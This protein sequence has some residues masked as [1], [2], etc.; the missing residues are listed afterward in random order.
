MIETD[1][2]TFAAPPKVG[3]VW[4]TKTL[5]RCGIPFVNGGEHTWGTTP[6][7]PSVTTRRDPANW[8]VSWWSHFH[9]YGPKQYRTYQPELKPLRECI[10]ED[11]S[12]EEFVERY[13]NQMPGQITRGYMAYPADFQMQTETLAVN[14]AD[15]LKMLE[16]P[17]ENAMTYEQVSYLGPENYTYKR[18]RLNPILTA[19]VRMCEKK[20]A[21]ELLVSA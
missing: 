17:L 9:E 12:L 14:F 8:L 6:G 7:K 13:L 4:I 2:F 3:C 20:T 21:K 19:R 1:W 10:V 5:A 11:E 18:V 16:V 15:L